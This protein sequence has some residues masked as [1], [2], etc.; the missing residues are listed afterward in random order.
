[1]GLEAQ[2]DKFIGKY[3]EISDELFKIRYSIESL[4][5]NNQSK[6]DAVKALKELNSSVKTLK[7][8]VREGSYIERN[9]YFP[10]YKYIFNHLYRLEKA[11][12][13]FERFNEDLKH[14]YISQMVRFFD[15]LDKN[16][17]NPEKTASEILS[18]RHDKS[19]YYRNLGIKKGYLDPNL[20]DYNPL[21]AEREFE[22]I[23]SYDEEIGHE[24]ALKCKKKAFKYGENALDNRPVLYLSEKA[25]KKANNYY[26][27]KTLGKDSVESGALFH[28]QRLERRKILL[29]EFKKLDT[30]D[31][32]RTTGTKAH[33]EKHF[34][35]ES[36]RNIIFC[37]SHPNTEYIAD[38]LS[39]G[40]IDLL[41]D[42]YTGVMGAGL[43]E[44]I[45]LLAVPLTEENSPKEDIVWVACAVNSE[46]YAGNYYIHVVQ[47]KENGFINVDDSYSWV[48][49][50]NNWI[51]PSYAS[52]NE[53]PYSYYKYEKKLK[54]IRHKI[55]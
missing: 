14:H 35:G 44:G 42:A 18:R 23:L 10:I 36:G 20:N 5:L 30:K 49:I 37:H 32:R 28:F 6:K 16:P 40:D 12:S 41:T 4:D 22:D 34:R 19:D 21:K 15:H 50:H 24:I 26:R 45:T 2:I 31:K 3:S 29:D 55:S 33:Q 9:D 39:S 17:D 13:H 54:K 51:K 8:D 53:G 25:L 52:K 38:R 11:K 27:N 43:R 48:N 1:M 47:Q 46:G 7:Y